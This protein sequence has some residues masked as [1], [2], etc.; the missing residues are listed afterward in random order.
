MGYSAL[1]ILEDSS[2]SRFG[3]GQN[4][5]LSLLEITR[6]VCETIVFDFAR[7][8]EFMDRARGSSIDV[9]SLRSGGSIVSARSASFSLG[10]AEILSTPILL[11]RSFLTV[12]SALRNKRLYPVQAL[13]YCATKKTVLIGLLLH[14]IGGY[15]YLF[16]AHSLDTRWSLW[17]WILYMPMRMAKRV[18]CVSEVVKRNIRTP[19]CRV[20]YN[21]GPRVETAT[22]RTLRASVHVAV[23][24]SL[25]KWKGI[26]YFMRSHR[27]LHSPSLVYFHI[28]GEGPERP[29]LEQYC[30]THVRIEGFAANPI[31][32]MRNFIDIIVVP[33]ISTEAC[34]MTPVEA[35]SCGIP[36]ITTNFGGQAEIVID[37]V[38]GKHVA[39]R[40]PRA[41]ASAIDEFLEHPAEYER[42]SHG[43]IERARAFDRELFAQKMLELLRVA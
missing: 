26:S 1:V 4:V 12:F 27:Y 20:V 7:T 42:L 10:A 36:V 34:P 43:A 23:F 33:S 41:I 40:S 35:L 29:F 3:G 39:P 16:H 15:Q 8:S 14:I 2:K 18:I 17:F 19:N 38:C 37:G 11:F 25:L 13:I 28:Y 9:R 5:T 22:K 6:G 21:P 32:K 31:E 24:A 30:G